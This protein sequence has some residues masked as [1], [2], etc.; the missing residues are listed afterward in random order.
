MFQLFENNGGL[1]RETVNDIVTVIKT[2][3]RK[4]I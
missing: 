3:E 1:V 2:E 4:K